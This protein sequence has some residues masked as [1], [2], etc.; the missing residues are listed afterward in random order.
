[1][2]GG[3]EVVLRKERSQ[4]GSYK[5]TFNKWRKIS[6]YAILTFLFVLVSTIVT[7]NQALAYPNNS[8]EFDEYVK[9]LYGTIYSSNGKRANWT[10][11]QRYDQVV[12]GSGHGR[13]KTGSQCGNSSEYEYLGYNRYGSPVNNTCFPNDKDAS[14]H[15]KQWDFQVVSGASTT[16]SSSS[17]GDSSQK[18][19]IK[20][21]GWT[22][23]GATLSDPLRYSHIGS[24]SK[25]KIQNPPT[26]SAQGS[27]YIQHRSRLTGKIW[28]A[29]FV[30]PPMAGKL[31]S[32][33][34]GTF[35]TDKY[36]YRIGYGQNSVPVNYTITAQANISGYMQ[37][38]HI[39][40]LK[41]EYGSKNNTTSGQRYSTLSNKLSLT[42]SQYSVGTHYI[43]LEGW[44]RLRTKYG[45]YQVKKVTRNIKLVVDPPI[46]PKVKT[47]VT[48]T[49]SEIRQ[50]QYK[51]ERVN[52]NV[53]GVVTDIYDPSQIAYYQF[54]ARPIED[55]NAYL[56]DTITTSSTTS[57]ISFT[58]TIPKSKIGTSG[59]LTQEY[60]GRVRVY[61]KDGSY[62][63]STDTNIVVIYPPAPP[64]AGFNT[65]KLSYWI[66]DKVSVT[67]TANSPS[68]DPLTYEYRIQRP[69]GTSFT[70]T[71]SNGKVSSNGNFSFNTNGKNPNYDVGTWRITQTVR[72]PYGL[73]DTISKT[74]IVKDLSINGSVYHT[75]EWQSK[76]NSKG[77]PWYYFYS[78]EEFQLNAAV[79]SAP[80]SWVKVD[81]QGYQKS[82][83]YYM[84]GFNLGKITSSVYRGVLNE[85]A[86]TKNSTALRNGYVTFNFTVQYQN[87]TI[88]TNA[89][90]V[91]IIGTVYDAFDY[92][93]RY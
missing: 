37:Y 40:A 74:F 2:K 85:P 33:L 3:G 44:V 91:Q 68:G 27:V 39:T 48:V 23:N 65:N 60:I 15:P 84:I 38:S 58:F 31:S 47:T 11:Y 86:F 4:M 93:R 81:F 49:P 6:S 87:G 36:E 88:R 14:T 54:I 10:Y 41:A 90:N 7:N 64:R 19:W 26:W 20:N 35:T 69:N 56:I 13:Y 32:I 66:G 43:K 30:V 50:N 53:K 75:P 59:S 22:G 8:T 79:S 57:N 46:Q 9:Q 76:H 18:S 78:G 5:K 25:V 1:M 42:R 92:H 67:S 24:Q 28:Y 89:V 16:W 83:N 73:S 70:Y 63:T 51:D 52:V 34:S 17:Y 55:T 72:N 45:D 12:F 71:T 80:I 21:S 77:N 82:G 61:M 62:I 29:T